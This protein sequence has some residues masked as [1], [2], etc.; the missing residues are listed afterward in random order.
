MHIARP[1]PLPILFAIGAA[2]AGLSCSK[3]DIPTTPPPP[4][5]FTGVA[6]S[7]FATPSP[8]SV[9]HAG[10]AYV[11]RFAVDYTLDP[12]VDATRSQYAIYADLA[13]FDST[14]NL[15]R[16]VGFGPNPPPGLTASS[17]A[18]SDSVS[19]T[20]TAADTPYIRVIAGIALKTDSTFF[21]SRG[22]RWSVH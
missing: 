9:L 1:G 12:A 21:F 8:A 13:T 22:P 10:Q 5:L 4:Y 7:K 14:D 2:L 17:G 18:V 20:V 6:V 15:L 3:D 19:F 16:V 11:V